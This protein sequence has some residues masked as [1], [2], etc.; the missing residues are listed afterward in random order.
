MRRAALL[1]LSLVALAAPTSRAA[2]AGSSPDSGRATAAAIPRP[3]PHVALGD[4]AHD[5]KDRLVRVVRKEGGAEVAKYGYLP[6]GRRNAKTT[7]PRTIRSFWDGPQEIEEQFAGT[8]LNTY[9]WAPGYVDDLAEFQKGGTSYFVHQDARHSV[10]AI[11]DASRTVVEKRRYDDFGNVQVVHGNVGL[12][13]GFQGRRF[14]PETGLYFFRARYYDPQTGRFLQRDP[15]WDPNN[16]GNQHTFVGNNPASLVDPSG[17]I[18]PLAAIAIVAVAGALIY[19]GIDVGVQAYTTGGF[20]YGSWEWQSTAWEAGLGAIVGATSLIGGPTSGGTARMVLTRV[21]L[22]AG[23]HALGHTISAGAD[24]AF[25]GDAAPDDGEDPDEHDNC[26]LA[27]HVTETTTRGAVPIEDVRLKD[28][29]APPPGHENCPDPSCGEVVRLFRNLTD[30]VVTITAIT[31]P[32][33]REHRAAASDDGEASEEDGEPPSSSQAIRCTPGHPFF[34]EGRGWVFAA[35]LRAGDA[36]EA[37]GVRVVVGTVGVKAERASTFN[38]EVR[39]HHTYRIAERDG[40][41]AVLVHNSSATRAWVAY[42]ARGGQMKRRQ[43]VQSYVTIRRNSIQGAAREATWG[44]QNAAQ[45]GEQLLRQRTLLDATGKRL[46]DPITKTGRRLDFVR[47]GPGNAIRE[48]TEV[49]SLSADKAAQMA[50]TGRLRAAGAFIRLPG[51]HGA[52]GLIPLGMT[53]AEALVRLP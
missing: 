4:V 21:A 52:Q 31:K 36:F 35:D 15:V 10:V 24:L 8:T 38:F 23:G 45:A 33:A 14:D 3:R 16:Y 28:R 40:A 41:P 49:T 39:C 12:E 13:Y 43:W 37:R 44:G 46:I 6:D 34:V 32:R 26:F 25:A 53:P 11:T 9:V 5:F 2:D 1:A 17:E 20:E 18:A 48:I 30:Q 27:G 47:V 19:G 51:T 42:L 50:K 7:P 29:I 22:E